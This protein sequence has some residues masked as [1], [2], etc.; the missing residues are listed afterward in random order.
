MLLT[1][2]L[3]LLLF[4]SSTGRIQYYEAD[5]LATEGGDWSV[6]F[7]P[8]IGYRI[9]TITWEF[10]NQT[11]VYCKYMGLDNGPVLSNY[12]QCP[13][14]CLYEQCQ[15]FDSYGIRIEPNVYRLF[16]FQAT[17]AMTG[18]YKLTLTFIGKNHNYTA[19]SSLIKSSPSLLQMSSLICNIPQI[20]EA[21]KSPSAAVPDKQNLAVLND[22]LKF[23]REGTH[24]NGSI[25]V[26][27]G[28]PE[29][30]IGVYLIRQPRN[31]FYPHYE[32]CESP[33]NGSLLNFSC[34]VCIEDFAMG[35][36]IANSVNSSISND[37]AL[38]LL[39]DWIMKRVVLW[40]F[41]MPNTDIPAS[42]ETVFGKDYRVIPL[43]IGWSAVVEAGKKVEIFCPL[44]KSESPYGID[45]HR[46]RALHSDFIDTTLPNGF[47]IEYIE[48]NK[49]FYL[50]KNSTEVTDSGVYGCTVKV[51]GYPQPICSDRRLYVIGNVIPVRIFL[52]KN[53]VSANELEPKDNFDQY[54]EKKIPFLLTSQEAYILC[55]TE[56]DTNNTYTLSLNLLKENG[57][58]TSE[59]PSN[60]T[61]AY[62]LREGT[63]IMRIF[64]FYRI[65]GEGKVENSGKLKA[66]CS[67][68]FEEL[69]N[70]VPGWIIDANDINENAELGQVAANFR[71][72]YM[73]HPTE[74]KLKFQ[75]TVDKLDEYPV[76]P[77]TV[78]RCSGASG[79]PEPVYKW[80]LVD[81]TQFS[82]SF[83][84]M[85]N[86]AK[87]FLDSPHDLPK[88]AFQGDHVTIPNDPRYRGMSYLLQCTASNKF[89]GREFSSQRLLFLTI[90]LCNSRFVTLD[91]SLIY[92]PQMVAG[93]SL[94]DL[95]NERS[96][97]D[98]YGERYVHLMRQ[99][100]LGLSY[101]GELIRFGLHPTSV[102]SRS[103][104]EAPLYADP[105][106]FDSKLSRIGLA[107]GFI[108]QTIRP[109]AIYASDP[110]ACPQKIPVNLN[111][112]LKTT[113]R[114]A[115]QSSKR[116]FA[117]VLP[118]DRWDIG[119]VDNFIKN[120]RKVNGK[121]ISVY[122]ED[123]KGWAK[124]TPDYAVQLA[125]FSG[126]CRRYSIVDRA[127]FINRL[128]LFDAICDVSEPAVIYDESLMVV[129]F[130]SHQSHQ[131]FLG[132]D[133][134]VF[135]NVRITPFD[136]PPVTV[137]LC[138]I[139]SEV[140][141]DISQ[142]E[143]DLEY[144]DGVCRQPLLKTSPNDTDSKCIT[145]QM[146][147][148]L[149][150]ELDGKYLL[151]YKRG[152]KSILSS[153]EVSTLPIR[154]NHGEFSKPTLRVKSPAEKALDSAEFECE[155]EMSRLRFQVYLIYRPKSNE[156]YRIIT[157][158][159][160]I[161]LEYS[162][163]NIGKNVSVILI[164]PYFPA[165]AADIG[166]YCVV[167]YPDQLKGDDLDELPI[168]ISAPV[169][170]NLSSICPMRP[171]IE[172]VNLSPDTDIAEGSRVTFVCEAVTG[173]DHMH[174]LQ[175][176]YSDL[177]ED[178]I[179]CSNRGGG[180]VNSTVPC[181]FSPW[182]TGG[183]RGL[184]KVLTDSHPKGAF[185]SC[186]I[187]YHET[188]N[189]YIRRI[190]YTIPML[191][192]Q[193]FESFIFCETLPTWEVEEENRFL[194]DPIDNYFP[195]GPIVTDI[196]P[197]YYE[198]IC[199]A[200]A[201]PEPINVSWVPIEA[202]P[203]KFADGIRKI[204]F[205]KRLT[206]STRYHAHDN[207]P[208]GYFPK[209]F[210]Q[211]DRASR[212]RF[213][214]V[215]P[216]P[217]V[218]QVG[219]W[220]EAKFACY[221]VSPDNKTAYEE[222]HISYGYGRSDGH[223]TVSG[224]IEPSTGVINPDETWRV[225][226]PL[227]EIEGEWQ[228]THLYLLAQIQAPSIQPLEIPLLYLVV[229]RTNSS[230]VI[231]GNVTTLGW[232]A[233][234]R[235]KEF[236]I[237]MATGHQTSQ[238]VKIDFP[239]ASMHDTGKYMCRFHLHESYNDADVV[240]NLI[241]LADKHSPIIGYIAENRSWEFADSTSKYLTFFDNQY[242]TSRCLIWR[243]QNPF[244]PFFT[245]P[246]IAES[247]DRNPNMAKIT[248]DT[249]TLVEKE[250]FQ[251]YIYHIINVSWY[252]NVKFDY[253]KYV[254]CY[255]TLDTKEERELG[256]KYGPLRICAPTES[257]ETRPDSSE[258]LPRNG[259]LECYDNGE[260]Y[261]EFAFTW[262]YIFGP[263]PRS[264][265][266]VEVRGI[267]RII[268]SEKLDMSL[269]PMPGFYIYKCIA[270]SFCGGRE[271]V[272]EKTVEFVV[273]G[274]EKAPA[275]TTVS[276]S[277]R[278]ILLPE[279]FTVECPSILSEGSSLTAV[280]LIWFRI[281][282]HPNT[283]SPHLHRFAEYL[284]YHDF[285]NNTVNV[286]HPNL[287][288]YHFKRS[289][290]EVFAID[291]QLSS[292]EDYGFYGCTTKALRAGGEMKD[293]TLSQISKKPL[294]IV[295]DNAGVQ[296]EPKPD[297]SD[298]C[299][300]EGEVVNVYCQA[301]AYE[302]FCDEEDKPVGSR[303]VDTIASVHITSEVVD[304]SIPLNLFSF[305]ILEWKPPKR[306]IQYAPAPIIITHDYHNAQLSCV[307]EP[308][309]LNTSFLNQDDWLRIRSKIIRRASKKLC[310]YSS[311][312]NFIIIP[313]PPEQV[314][315]TKVAFT[316]DSGEWITCIAS[317]NPPPTVTLDAYPIRRGALAEAMRLG[318]EGIEH[319]R[320]Y[321]RAQPDWPSAPLKNDTGSMMLVLRETNDP[322]DITYFGVCRGTNR[323]NKTDQ[324][325]HKAF[326][327]QIRDIRGFTS[328]SSFNHFL[329]VAFIISL[330]VFVLG[331]FIH[332]ILVLRHRYR[333]L[334]EE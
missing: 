102:L 244:N 10:Q 208:S 252:L 303:F 23:V 134:S 327:F 215:R 83:I 171:I 274:D 111:G 87:I 281:Y 158:E 231:L 299:Y 166:I 42:P 256:Q 292:Y 30:K 212:Y 295:D 246:F 59:Y 205:F 17:N 170:H 76:P 148:I 4:S 29:G 9:S 267:P 324:T 224:S 35:I 197:G 92:S 152:A 221:I 310:V 95:D 214:L 216:V 53:L 55:W 107:E 122:F 62:V 90:C 241:V 167:D 298:D 65:S 286:S 41:D 218:Y 112:G 312:A 304:K 262:V 154:L 173:N 213:Q 280:S 118:R 177:K 277:K 128:P 318:L 160:S 220:G 49:F 291:I 16:A 202:T 6:K 183:C 190:E 39:K 80:T 91:L 11:V 51:N 334:K 316:I 147:M 328:S 8:R 251:H 320:D 194:S 162:Y 98:I 238:V 14:G 54:A 138:L 332:E 37:Q 193:H 176:S 236:Q 203:E 38:S 195:V 180:K 243:F 151:A 116:P 187:S 237:S 71:Y 228:L 105:T 313:S 207:S 5:R 258:P 233:N 242:F 48:G 211:E 181:M 178:L 219:I 201:Y 255:W 257:L 179:I 206:Q 290:R 115:P 261:H 314:S 159:N 184:E 227:Q 287:V 132:E 114:D 45:C 106:L 168:L 323:V 300:T 67:T 101:G 172:R 266:S 225:L 43:K 20:R 78:I 189:A 31:A 273:V 27:L 141:D 288:A 315:E 32:P 72:I 191:S 3:Y 204:A 161:N 296:I 109:Q 230:S 140:A 157:R 136:Q 164:W 79:Y 68:S 36:F 117:V 294:C 331:T 245:K 1:L 250:I 175:M 306:T 143:T 174:A 200:A 165:E 145:F 88:Y 307:I 103:L 124:D 73:Y 156:T 264:N 275:F 7:I 149:N 319:W 210:H 144:L 185:A 108:S 317:G 47:W 271:M 40:R 301:T 305:R 270:S 248:K 297:R 34:Q 46:S 302:I 64:K 126:E 284:S 182:N 269:L 121:V 133:I 113:L 329:I 321:S 188:V 26:N 326:I 265:E 239:K 198:W 28:L 268:K 142:G 137:W 223:W 94:V 222:A 155:F 12:F 259:V 135:V 308:E 127:S 249:A 69:Q 19:V 260:I 163:K 289:N 33:V 309:L 21:L 283:V 82:S 234:T 282:Q 24:I 247:T 279:K 120:I 22:T 169:Y 130:L 272:S 70:T 263:L 139:D 44:E 25:E 66:S 123:P 217:Y 226:C 196:D 125:N 75:G 18:D 229:N 99:I 84:G 61:H 235:G 97:L 293:L 192:I 333:R 13:K 322:P 77:G 52:Y 153:Q 278:L 325:T 311:A 74:G 15:A 199:E 86:A 209:K 146:S 96:T 240:P 104:K 93:I 63:H 253:N 56:T 81:P 110:K 285:I 89:A 276:I 254:G 85:S 2:L 232:W 186:T 60:L 129:V 119:D 57:N 50:R 330:L 150:D 58:S 100:I 131:L